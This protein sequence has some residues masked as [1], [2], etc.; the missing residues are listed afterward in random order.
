MKIAPLERPHLR[1]LADLIAGDLFIWE[2]HVYVKCAHSSIKVSTM[3][4]SEKPV[5]CTRLSDG[6]ILIFEEDRDQADHVEVPNMI[7][8]DVDTYGAIGWTKR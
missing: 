8:V 4:Q 2:N 6:E 1:P 3:V 7:L 5:L